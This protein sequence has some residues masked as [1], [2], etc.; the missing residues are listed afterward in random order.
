ML[1]LVCCELIY[2]LNVNIPTNLIKINLLRK[3]IFP[4]I[5]INNIYICPP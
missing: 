2:F 3:E 5:N 1:L 4:R